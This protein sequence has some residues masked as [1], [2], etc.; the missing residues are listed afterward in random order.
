M[1]HLPTD[2][3]ERLPSLSRRF[4]SVCSSDLLWK[5]LYA[6]DFPSASEGGSGE[7][8]T[9]GARGAGGMASCGF[10]EAYARQRV[11]MSSGNEVPAFPDISAAA[12]ARQGAGQRRDGGIDFAFRDLSVSNELEEIISGGR[13][14]NCAGNHGLGGGRG[15]FF[16]G[17]G[18]GR[19]GGLNEGFPGEFGDFTLGGGFRSGGRGGDQGEFEG[20]SLGGRGS[21]VGMGGQFVRD[22]PVAFGGEYDRL[23]FT[24]SP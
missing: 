2:L 10:K 20:F 6:R 21:A 22:V 1:T 14:V 5:A 16:G 24:A 15:N 11:R 8:C 4:K 12:G 9:S 19:V 18:A 3:V 17:D 23:P 7:E 13:S